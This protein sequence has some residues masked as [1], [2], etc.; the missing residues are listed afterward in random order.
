MSKASTTYHIGDVHGRADLVT[1]L[2]RHLEEDAYKRGALPVFSFLGDLVDR[3]P[4]SKGS[5]QRVLET[6]QNWPGSVL[7]LGNHDEWF[8]DALDTDGEFEHVESWLVHGGI[9][10]VTSYTGKFELDSL[11]AIREGFPEHVG[12]L[13]LARLYTV[14]G[15]F[16]AVHAGI[17]PTLPLN[18]QRKKHLTWIREPFLEYVDPDL[19]PVVHGHTIVGRLP[20]VTENR[21]SIDTGAYHTGRLT[22]LAV[23]HDRQAVRFIQAMEDGAVA[24]VEPVR[25]DRGYGTLLDRIP[26]LFEAYSQLEPTP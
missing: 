20:V 7:H 26:A 15:P 1:S 14:S 18:L 11:R 5:V 10:T 24:E 22:C 3:G 17:D 8:L 4:D 16:V 6:L 19:R 13:K 12:L 25:V 2:V 9:A 23:D 21:I